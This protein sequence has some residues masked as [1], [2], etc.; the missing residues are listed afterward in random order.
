MGSKGEAIAAVRQIL[1]FRG[2]G[3][4]SPHAENCCSQFLTQL[5]RDYWRSLRYN[6]LQTSAG[7]PA[8]I[9][10]SYPN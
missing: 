5:F 4:N 2:M 8:I 3:N 10:V 9:A 7:E 1:H 6:D